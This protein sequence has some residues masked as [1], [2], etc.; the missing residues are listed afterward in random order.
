M[1]EQL[2]EQLAKVFR[3]RGDKI[4]VADGNAFHPEDCTAHAERIEAEHLAGVRCLGFYLL[5]EES[6]CYVSCAD[7]DNKPDRPDPL[8][9]E[10][11]ERVYFLLANVGL[12][13]LVEVSQS[14]DA[15]HVWLSFREPV[16]AWLA[17]AFWRAVSSK[18]ELP[19]PE[20]YPRQDTLAKGG[21]GNLVRYPLWNQSRFVDVESDWETIVPAEA[22]SSAA[23]TDVGSLRLYGWELCGSELRPEATAVVETDDGVLPARVHEKLKKPHTLL[24]RRWFGD[25]FGMND[26]S[27]SALV[28]AIAC[29]LVRAYV[30]TAEICAALRVWCKSFGYEKGEREDWIERTTSKAYDFVFH[31]LEQKSAE[32]STLETAA[33]D[34]LESIRSGTCSAVKSGIPDL[35]A[36]IEGV[37]FGEVAIVAGL[38]GHGKTALAMQWILSAAGEGMPGLILSE[39][40]SRIA[41]GKRVVQVSTAVHEEH[42]REHLDAVAGHVRT[43]FQDRALIRVREQ[44]GTI[45]RAEELIDQH[46][47]VDGVRIVAIDYLQLLG[48]RH[49]KRYEDVSEVSRRLKQAAARNGCA[50]L[51]CCQL[52][53]EI[54]KRQNFEP[55]NSDLR[56]SGQI[57]QDADLILFAQWPYRLQC[58]YQDESEYRIYCTKRRNGPVNSPVVITTWNPE[59][60]IVGWSPELEADAYSFADYSTEDNDA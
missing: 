30:P 14:G 50:M 5:D 10:K 22:L 51:V 43:L 36:S 12:S 2:A 39:E 16:P 6:H 26:P 9:R 29:E 41:L 58:D 17:R 47:Q 52:N 55:R 59:R 56:E 24:S 49:G 19:I 34:Y 4:A 28:Q 38:P 18:L 54:N 23:R 1:S 40:M 35:D 33:I 53:R 25:T 3:G 44:C 21:L 13:P 37:G 32:C 27:K 31:R 57:E 8:W 7:F 48:S 60:Q 46:C 45:D 42:W 20:V 15:A 11:A